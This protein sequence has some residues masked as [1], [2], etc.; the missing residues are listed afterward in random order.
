MGDI[1]LGMKAFISLLKRINS[2][3]GFL[4]SLHTLGGNRE[5]QVL[6]LTLALMYSAI[7]RASQL[8][9]GSVSHFLNW[10]N[11]THLSFLTVGHCL[12]HCILF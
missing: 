1:L 6:V 5:N 7:L 4:L 11:N 8:L 10:D 2:L 12:C 9:W 3:D